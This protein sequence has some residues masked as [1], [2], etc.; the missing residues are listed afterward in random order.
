MSVAVLTL[1]ELLLQHNGAAKPEGNVSVSLAECACSDVHSLVMVLGEGLPG[2]QVG[3]LRETGHV[4][5]VSCSCSAIESEK[6]R[7]QRKAKQLKA[8]GAVDVPREGVKQ[9]NAVGGV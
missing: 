1:S 7:S 2:G 3:G 5:S 4:E 9:V 8:G 6:P